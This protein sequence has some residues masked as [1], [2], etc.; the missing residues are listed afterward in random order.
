MRKRRNLL[1]RYFKTE[2]DSYNLKAYKV[3]IKHIN[4]KGTVIYADP[5]ADE[6]IIANER[7]HYYLIVTPKRISLVNT[8]DVLNLNVNTY[9][10]DK[11]REKIL[12]RVHRDRENLKDSILNRKELNL[13]KI[14]TK[15]D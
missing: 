4:S 6:Y 11:I 13:D 12:Q 15:L 9:I 1:N 10:E 3:M 7:T 8:T 2:L 5:S 14:L